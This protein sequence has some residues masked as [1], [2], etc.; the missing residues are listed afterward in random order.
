MTL[1]Y[2]W[3]EVFLEPEHQTAIPWCTRHDSKAY[4]RE[5]D[6][7]SSCQQADGYGWIDQCVISTGGPD[8]KWW[9]DE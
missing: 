4:V 6:L 7:A 2:P 1:S 3:D 9:R 8:H 5:D